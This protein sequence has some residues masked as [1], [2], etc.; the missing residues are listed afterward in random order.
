MQKK[1]DS[2]DDANDYS[3]AP[4][5]SYK[6]DNDYSKNDSY[7]KNASA[8]FSNLVITDFSCSSGKHSGRMTCKVKNNNSFTVHGYFRVNFYDASGSLIYSQLM[9]L[10]DVAPG[11]SVV[12][13]TSIPKDDYPDGYKSYDFSQASLVER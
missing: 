6:Y 7:E 11:E 4:K 9:S 3:S 13:S 2:Q 1:N 10:S 5:F 8:I 12:C